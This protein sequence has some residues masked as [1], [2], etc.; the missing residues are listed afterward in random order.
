MLNLDSRETIA[1]IDID[2]QY[3]FTPVCPEELPVPDGQNIAHELNRQAR[4][5]QYR[6]GS[7]D[8]HC[9]NAI[10]VADSLH[11]TL[12]PMNHP[13]VDVHWPKHCVP[14]TKG[15]TLLESLPH[16]SEYDFFIWKG[17]EPDMHP[18]GVCFHDL[19]QKLSTGLIEYL[20]SKK[21][22][23]ILVGGLATDYCVKVSAIQLHQANFKVIVNLAAT[24]GLSSITTQQ[25]L[26]EMQSLG[27]L[28]IHS[29]DELFSLDKANYASCD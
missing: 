18:Y 9:A 15:F 20:K 10:W 5:A 25:A 21:V 2:A 6:I 24:R 26:D 13:Q 16:P 22:T 4:F 3:G 12:S 8:A 17:V 1:S 7:K 19:H 14:G 27:I 11:P 29:C 23:T 28:L